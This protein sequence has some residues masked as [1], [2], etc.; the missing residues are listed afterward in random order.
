KLV[1]TMR[2]PVDCNLLRKAVRSAMKRYPYFCVFPQR[3]GDQIQLC[4]NDAPVPVWEDGR[5]VTLGSKECDGHL[6]AF[7]CEERRILL[8][9]SHYI[10]DGMG[11][12]PLLMT[13]LYLYVSEK[14]GTDGLN[15]KRIFMPNDPVGEAE[16]AYPFP[17][18]PVLIHNAGT[19]GR[20]LEQ[21]YS[22]DPDA[23]DKKG[24]YA[25]HLRI[26][27][28]AMMKVANPSDGSPVSFLSVMLYRALCALDKDLDKSVVAHVQHQYRGAL[29]VPLNRHSLV[30]YIPVELSPKIKDRRVELQNTILRGQ[31]IIGSEPEND[32]RAVNRLVSV[33]PKDKP[34]SLA[35][36]QVAMRQYIENSICGKTFGISYV[37]KMDWCGIDRYVEDL[38]AYIG[39]KSTANMILI[40]VMTVGENFSVNF[41]QSGRGTRYVTAFMEQLKNFGIPVTLAGEERYTLCDTILSEKE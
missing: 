25:Y 23:F 17:E 5:C 3:N 27:Q 28:I 12:C 10:A 36:K 40:E 2:D 15:S 34:L 31:I 24:L 38:H 6:L 22:P 7:G 11:I 39:E 30:N 33:F 20:P 8:H 14:Y 37:G 4:F 35:E 21:V 29:N 1:V 16:Y 9:V 18:E 19:P 41:M 32:L 26:P 13:V